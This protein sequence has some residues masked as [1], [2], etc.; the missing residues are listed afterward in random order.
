MPNDAAMHS[1]PSARSPSAQPT[2]VRRSSVHPTPTRQLIDQIAFWATLLLG[3]CPALLF[4][5]RP[6]WVI[7]PTAMLTGGFLAITVLLRLREPSRPWSWNKRLLALSGAFWAVVVLYA[8]AQA[9]PIGSAASAD[10]P[11]REAAALI[12]VDFKA[13]GSLNAGATLAGVLRLTLYA[14]LCLLAYMTCRGRKRGW[15]ILWA[16]VAV[17][18]I[19]AVYAILMKVAGIDAVLWQEKRYYLGWATG[20]FHNRNTFAAFLGIGLT[21]NVAVFARSFRHAVPS[22][23]EGRE[24]L[25]LALEFLTRKGALIAG[26]MLAMAAAGLMT[27]SRAGVAAMAIGA[28]LTAGAVAIRWADG[29]R[30]ARMV[31]ALAVVA[32]IVGLLWVLGG[33]QTAGRGVSIETSLDQRLQIFA[34]TNRAIAQRPM[35]GYGLGAFSEAMHSVK[36]TELVNDWRRAHNTY[37]EL[38]LELGWP[39]AL[40]AFAAV[41]MVGAAAA[42]G[43]WT[44]RRA[45]PIAAAAAA[46]LILTAAHSLVDFPL[47]EPGVALAL[48]LLLGT[49]AAQAEEGGNGA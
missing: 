48:A 21:A 10:S 42:R 6:L 26:P 45:A 34:D 30:M 14:S 11:W 40:I 8:A 47:Q 35:S 36:S 37:L 31:G 41:G 43:L 32:A 2:S 39:M 3:V 27:G 17:G 1:P 4:A 15:I 7:A 25:R 5:G 46:S 16:L 18:G 13:R 9:L 19:A 28:A 38:A 22:E 23:I 44:R 20:P 12:G 49:A 24:R 33:G 29:R